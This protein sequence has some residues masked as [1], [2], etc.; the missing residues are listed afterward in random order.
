MRRKY[1]IGLMNITL[2][3]LVLVSAIQLLTSSNQT[4]TPANPAFSYPGVKGEAITFGGRGGEILRVTNLSS[5]GPGSLR[6]ALSASGPRIVVFEVAGAID[7]GGENISITD[8]HLTVAGQTAPSPGVTVLKGGLIIRT[9]DVIIQHLR[10]RPGDLHEAPRSGRD[11]DAI[12]T[13]GA[14]DVIV[15][16]NSLTWATDENLSASGSRFT[17][18]TPDQWRE[19]TSS[20]ILFT[21]N[22]IAEGLAHSTHAKGEHSKGSLIHDNASGITI[23]YNL[24]AHNYERSPLFKGGARGII[25]NNLIY[26]PG[27]RAIHYNLQSLEWGEAEYQDGMMAVVGNVMRGGPSTLE[28]LPMIMIGGAGDLKLAAFDNIAV[29][30]WGE[31]LPLLGRYTNTEATIQSE[32]LRPELLRG[33]EILPASAVQQYVLRNVGAR[34][35]DRDVHDVR[36]LADT[37]EGRG[38]IIDSQ[39]DVG[40]YPEFDEVY[41]S[42]DPEEWDLTTMTP[43]SMD[44][45]GAESSARGT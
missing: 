42:F 43:K 32:L 33:L 13:I 1:R 10:I 41:R 45:L 16:H 14:R 12:T 24:Y 26:N 20:N 35:W 27:A 18:T 4:Q 8:P 40:G 25:A 34:P 19:G 7:L 44:V 38:A 23:A 21:N 37:A 2:P 39:E 28:G 31:P 29:D 17:G 9:H 22:L 5:D 15:D 11:I 6:A 3:M 30:R 36:V